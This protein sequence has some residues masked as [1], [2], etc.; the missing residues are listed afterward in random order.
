MEK[1]KF[2]NILTSEGRVLG[3]RGTAN[4]AGLDVKLSTG[5]EFS[6]SLSSSIDFL[7][8]K[9]SRLKFSLFFL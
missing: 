7:S 1:N 6:T 4:G 5:K 3:G 9:I 2:N 8:K